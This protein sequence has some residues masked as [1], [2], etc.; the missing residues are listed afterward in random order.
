MWLVYFPLCLFTSVLAISTFDVRHNGR[1]MP[2]ASNLAMGV[3]LVGLLAAAALHWRRRWPEALVVATSLVPLI[4]PLDPVP[5]LIALGSLLVRRVDRVAGVL[6]GLVTVSTYVA[7]WRDSRGTS[8]QDSFFQTLWSSDTGARFE[9]LSWWVVALITAGLVVVCVGLALLIRFRQGFTQA[10]ARVE[11]QQVVVD[12]LS[13]EVGRQAE[14]ERIAQ[15][16]HDALGHRLSLLSLHAGAL[17]VNAGEDQRVA[18]AAKLLRVN[19]QQSMVDLRSLLAVLRQPDSPDV[20]AVVPTL[21]DIASLVDDTVSTGVNL[22]STVQID[23]LGGLAETTSR[24]AYRITQ[25][26]LTN[27]RKHA[28]GIGVRVL[29]RAAPESGVQIEVAN[30]LPAEAALEFRPGSGLDGIRHRVQALDGDFRCFVD[31]RR[32]FRV[33]VRLPWVP[34]G[35]VREERR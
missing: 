10:S 11:D 5:S 18:D 30:H 15:E 20:A 12:A 9:P 3:W 7:I 8:I 13:D 14:R 25:E 29:V 33:A 6:I 4:F 21:A 19:A 32:V 34:E 31:Q 27:A 16:V 35:S 1:P 17:E 28:P 2:T 24:S 22:V 23:G 26:L